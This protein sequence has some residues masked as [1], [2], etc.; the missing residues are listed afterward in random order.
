MKFY[1]EKLNKLFEDEKSLV[2]AEDE[3]DVRVAAEKAKQVPHAY[4]RGHC[5]FCFLR[6]LD[7]QFY[8]VREAK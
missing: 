3:Y 7:F 6:M 1:S 2:K 5:L 8:V 4:L